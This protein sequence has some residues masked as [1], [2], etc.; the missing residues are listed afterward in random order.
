M[1][2]NVY[3]STTFNVWLFLFRDVETLDWVT[4]TGV[5]HFLLVQGILEKKRGR[6]QI[7]LGNQTEELI[8]ELFDD[9]NLEKI[10]QKI[11]FSIGLTSL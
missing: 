9:A 4:R 6:I 3:S 7:N 5:Q 10:T 2:K 11:I 8:Q 1:I